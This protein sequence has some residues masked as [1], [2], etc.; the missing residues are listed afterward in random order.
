MKNVI[1]SVQAISQKTIRQ[2]VV[3]D[4]TESNHEAETINHNKIHKNHL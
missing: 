2:N 4:L 3:Y 1:M